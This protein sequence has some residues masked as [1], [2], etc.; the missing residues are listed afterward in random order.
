V[1]PWEDG[2]DDASRELREMIAPM[3]FRDGPG[4][5]RRLAWTNIP[6]V[7]LEPPR[8]RVW[9]SNQEQYRVEFDED[10][11]VV[12]CDW[13][14]VRRVYDH[15]SI[16]SAGGS[17]CDLP[18]ESL[19]SEPVKWIGRVGAFLL[20]TA[21]AVVVVGLVAWVIGPPAPPVI[22]PEAAAKIR[23][24]MTLAEVESLLGKP[25]GDYRTNRGA[26]RRPPLQFPP[27][28][29]TWVSDDVHVVVLFS[30]DDGRV[31]RVF[32]RRLAH[33]VPGREERLLDW[34]AGQ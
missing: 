26:A 32:N 2:D 6:G 9:E 5:P 17:A 8:A 34:A 22:D 11:R 31:N 4:G 12:R 1:L 15:P 21:I 30:F 10:G 20:L 16:P 3:W 13:Q 7:G 33:E 25:A 28:L 18:C 24:G 29:R 23:A 19:R 14:A 27:D